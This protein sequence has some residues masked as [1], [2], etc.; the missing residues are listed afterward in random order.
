MTCG[1]K[2]A[3]ASCG[4]FAGLLCPDGLE[5]VDDPD[6]GCDPGAG[7][8]DCPGICV[9]PSTGCTGD[10]DC[11]ETS[12]CR[13]TEAGDM[14]CT[15]YK[16][17][18]ESCGG[19]TPIWAQT[20]CLPSLACEDQTPMIADD[21]GICVDP[22]VQDACVEDS[23]CVFTEY[24]SVVTSVD[25]CF[26]PMCPEWP[27]TAS[28]HA[29]RAA[30]W[31]E[32]CGKWSAD[33]PC[34][35]TDCMM[36]G[37]AICDA[38]QCI[39][40]E[41][42]C[43]ITGCAGQLC[44]EQVMGSDCGMEDWYICFEQTTCGNFAEDGGCGW[45]PNADFMQCIEFFQGPPPSCDDGVMCDAMPPVCP[46]GLTPVELNGCW[47][48][49]FP[50]TC[51][52]DD[53]SMLTCKAPEPACTADTVLAVKNGCYHCVDPMTCGIQNGPELCGGFAGWTCPDGQECVDNPDDDCDPNSGGADCIG[54]CVEPEPEQGCNTS[55]ECTFTE[56]ETMVSNIDECFCP[57][58]PTWPVTVEEHNARSSAWQQHCGQWSIDEPCPMPGCLDP[59]EAICDKGECV[60]APTGCMTTGC[61]GEICAAEEV[62]STCQV[63]D[64][65]ACLELTTCGNFGL[66]GTCGWEMNDAYQACLDSFEEPAGC[67]TD[68]VLCKKAVPECPEGLTPVQNGVCWGCGYPETC[69]CDDGSETLCDMVPPTCV[70]PSILAEQ[71]GCY[72]CVDPMT[73]AP[74]K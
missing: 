41:Q 15:P 8:A 35:V 63:E 54:I 30:A 21:P 60:D 40:E 42:G 27:V 50:N 56:F 36:S 33:L 12:W 52:C 46:S 11:D 58:C 49:G 57:M 68:G 22:T 48:C 69:S 28:E 2:V 4:G 26:C 23:D 1:A 71:G 72:L 65:Y 67:P 20:K 5:C 9:P 6:D 64:W 10:K 29:A 19:F 51:S 16:L 3:P 73:C 34:P 61:K 43:V 7:G 62:F 37:N 70:G 38:G 18:G 13:P 14:E 59:G 66:D 74:P 45:E 32:H 25:E 24:G 39:E 47:G 53:G 31:Q 44:A 17:E 55:D